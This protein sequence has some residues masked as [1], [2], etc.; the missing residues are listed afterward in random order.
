MSILPFDLPAD[1]HVLIIGAGGGF[2]F[3]CGVPLGLELQNQGHEVHY[4]S[5]S[6]TDLKKFIL[7]FGMLKACLKLMRM[8]KSK[9]MIISRKNIWPNGFAADTQ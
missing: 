9:V 8:L 4:A 3:L 6:F 7:R 2:D 1:S 5:Y